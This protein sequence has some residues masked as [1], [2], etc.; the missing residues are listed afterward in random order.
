MYNNWSEP[1]EGPEAP[2]GVPTN[3]SDIVPFDEAPAEGDRNDAG[4]PKGAGPIVALVGGMV[5]ASSLSALGPAVVAAAYSFAHRAGDVSYK[6]L[7]CALAVVG[8]I[9]ASLATDATAAPGAVVMVVVGLVVAWLHCS[10]S[11]TSGRLILVVAGATVAHLLVDEVLMRLSGT[12]LS[13]YMSAYL[14]AY[15]D[16]V[17]EA[18]ASYDLSTQIEMS[19]SL[20]EL[21]SF[22]GTFWPTMYTVAALVEYLSAHVGLW[23]ALGGRRGQREAAA[24]HGT[25]VAGLAEFDAP[26][27]AVALFLASVAVVAVEATVEALS[28]ELVYG[29]SANLAMGF[30]FV[31][32]LQGAAVV[33]WLLARFHSGPFLRVAAWLLAITLELDFYVVTIVGLV[34]VWANF[35]HLERGGGPGVQDAPQQG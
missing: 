23:L 20:S 8:A 10:G 2:E 3:G 15:A 25:R 14:A 26:L 32:V 28:S 12:T 16:L 22:M 34:D 21:T 30:R 24:G 9:V 27:L 18:Y 31:F 35:R 7:A 4:I 13:A 33:T 17:T 5:C 29:L 1:D 11:M 6:G 19:S